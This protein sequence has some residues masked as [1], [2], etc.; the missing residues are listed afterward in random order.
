MSNLNKDN[1]DYLEILRKI[2]KTPGASQRKLSKDLGFSLEKLNY[3]L[4]ELQTKGLVKI[5][6][7][8]QNE[9]KINYLYA[10][11]PLGISR[12]LKLVIFISLLNNV[13]VVCYLK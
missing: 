8:K 12:K 11:T 10:L 2:S 1:N 4:H 6:N 5:K 3:C 13:K 9:K 7:L